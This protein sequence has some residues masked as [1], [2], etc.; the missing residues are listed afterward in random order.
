M[1]IRAEYQWG[2][3]GVATIGAAPKTQKQFQDRDAQ[4]NEAARGFGGPLCF[5]NFGAGP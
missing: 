2:E 5:G 4:A 1:F 3:R